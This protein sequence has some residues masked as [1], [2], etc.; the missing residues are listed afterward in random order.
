MR[1]S[2]NGIQQAVFYQALQVNLTTDIQQ[3]EQ[4]ASTEMACLVGRFTGKD[5]Q[6]PLGV[7]TRFLSLVKRV[8]AQRGPGITKSTTQDS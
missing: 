2:K 5:I 3:P 4:K 7:P 6:Y 8:D 1:S